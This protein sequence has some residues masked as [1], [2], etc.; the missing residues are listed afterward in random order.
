MKEKYTKVKVLVLTTFYDD[1]SITSAIGGGADGYLLKDSGKDAILG[2]ISQII[3]GRDVIDKKVMKLKDAGL[4]KMVL[5]QTPKY[6]R[7][8][9]L[10]IVKAKI[11]PQIMSLI[12][13]DA[14]FDQIPVKAEV[15]A[16][17]SG[18]YIIGVKNLRG[19]APT[20]VKRKGFLAKLRKKQSELEAQVA[21]EE[22]EKKNK[23]NQKK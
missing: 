23:K 2:A 16:Q 1:K 4:P 21:K 5:D 22:A 8:S 14:I 10:P 19:V 20:P 3:D 7:N 6:L 12:C 9:K 18:I 17:I 11:G 15:K 13:D